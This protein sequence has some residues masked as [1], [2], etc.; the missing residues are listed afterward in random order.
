[1]RKALFTILCMAI[2]IM[3]KAQN[4]NQSVSLNLQIVADTTLHP[5]NGNPTTS[6]G[7][8]GHIRFTSELGFVRFVVNDNYDD[9]YM[10]YESYRLFE[11][12][13]S[14]NFSQRCE[15][16]CF[17][18]SYVPTELIVQVKDAIVTISTID[19]SNAFYSN[20]EF[21][22]LNA[23]QNANNQKLIKVQN[24][25]QRKGLI[26]VADATKLSSL[27]YKQ[28]AEYYGEGYRTYGYEFYS[29][30]FFS[31][32]GPDRYSSSKNFVGNFDWRNRHG[33]NNSQSSYYDGDPLGTGW[34]TPVVCQSE[35]CWLNGSFDCYL[36][37]QQ[38]QDLGGDYREA[39]TCWI[40]GPTA[41]VEAMTNL[42]YN[43]HLDVDLSEQ[44]I[45]CRE[46]KVSGSLP[47]YALKYYKQD[48]VPLESCLAYSASLGNCSD[49]CA[50][51]LVRVR[52]SNY[53]NHNYLNTL[54]D[55]LL[56]QLIIN[57]G[58]LTAGRLPL[59]FGMNNHCMLL[60]GWGTID[61]DIVSEVLGV[62]TYGNGLYDEDFLGL[63]Y[64][65]YK[66]SIGTDDGDNGFK[67]ILHI[68]NDAPE[69]TGSVTTPIYYDNLTERDVRCCDM[70]GDGYY[71]WGIGP[72]P[73]HCPPCPDEPD[74]D[75]SNPNLGPLNS[76]GQCTIIGTY[77][78][79]FEEGWDNWMQVDL[80]NQE[81]GIFWRDNRPS[82]TPLTGPAYAQDGDYY[83]YVN[84]RESA[85]Y[86]NIYSILESPDINIHNSCYNVLDFY[87]HMKVYDWNNGTD[88]PR[89][90]MMYQTSDNNWHINYNFEETGDHGAE[91]Q[92]ASVIL[93]LNVKKIRLYVK[94]GQYQYSDVALD[95]I[96]IGPWSHNETPIVITDNTEWNDNLTIN[97]DIVVENGGCLTIK[98]TS[99][100]NSIIK[101]HS[102]SKIIVKQGGRLILDHCTLTTLCSND[103]W[104]G[105][106]VWGN[107]NTHQ[108]EVNGSYLQ[109]YIELKNGAVIENAKCAVE[110]WHPEIYSTSGGIIHA[111]DATFRNNAKAVHALYYTYSPSGG[112]S[113]YNGYLR[114]CTFTIDEDY[115]GTETFSKHVD[116]SHISGFDIEGC[117]FSTMRNVTGVSP[118]CVGIGAYS[119][120]F[121]VDSY[122]DHPNAN[123]MTACPE[124]NL[125]PCSF[126]NFYQGIHASCDKGSTC[127]FRIE[128]AVFSNNTCG[129]YALNT[130]YGIVVNNDFTVG[131]GWDCDFGI[132]ADGVSNFCIEDNTFQP[133]V[134]NTG[135]PY[136]IAIVNSKSVND[137]YNNDFQNL[138]CGNVA[139][140]SNIVTRNSPSLTVQGLT[141]TCN[142]NS[143]NLIDFCVLKD[144][145]TGDIATQQGS[146]T[147][148]AG[149]TFSGSQYHFYNDGNNWIGYYYEQNNPS[150]TP[151]NTSLYRVSTHFTSSSNSCNSHY[152]G[153]SVTKSAAEKAALASEYLS[154]R[155]TYNSLLQL[156][157]SRIDGGSTPAQVTDINTATPSDLWQL[158]A[159]L[160]G[161][162]PYVSGEV[163]TTAADRYDVFTDPVLFEIL[164]ANPDELRKD[165]LISYLETKDHPLPTYMTDLLRE[166][167]SGFTAR[168][169]LLG[170]MAQYGHDFRLAAGDIVRSC[171]NDSVTDLTELRTW[172]ANMD[173]IASDRMIVASYLQEGDSVHAFGLANMLPELYGLQGD[174]LADHTDYMR[175]IELYQTLNRES[176]NVNTLTDTELS[177]VNGIA[178]SGTGTSKTMAEAIL[179]ERSDEN[180]LSSE[181]P[182]MPG[183]NGGIRGSASFK[184]TSLNEA[185]GFTASVSPNPATTWTTVEYTLPADKSQ[186]SFS[187]TNT[188]GVIVMSTELNG[189]QGQK[190]LDLHGLADGVYFYTIRCGEYTTTGKLV[191]TK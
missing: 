89:I 156:Y 7:I 94:T 43:R 50:D 45:A 2:G 109:G 46:H 147:M 149:N 24:Y 75:D 182:T 190:V 144:G 129:L 15:E 166:M 136:G 28:K 72:K 117:S 146:A 27:S 142:T 44:Y 98:K 184:D 124:E 183:N 36:D 55:M 133:K 160:L 99:G 175:L 17:F 145:N 135:S 92:H 153:G 33:A 163:L 18:G 37:A 60:V 93:P 69:Y 116:L 167:A 177:M 154:A 90:T 107:S 181:C 23:T 78:A 14:F 119:A 77:T 157:E 87:Y 180:I 185:M 132:Y 71:N 111:T 189:K 178:A 6:I 121:R 30:G 58:P 122:C 47:V 143:G 21:L 59:G 139:V 103:M 127:S 54:T 114:N 9:E 10:V 125:V 91:W 19:M 35:G 176:R 159:Q 134:T 70:D 188:L 102:D 56:K 63:T 66:E 141:Y 62:P 16:S 76:Y 52:I 83:I 137:V 172:L 51:S 155:S 61:D 73:A 34:I 82:S 39:S 8:S 49:L 96:T 26:W 131:C 32:F 79:S 106:E 48:G 186:A 25:I 174:A 95:N 100:N 138:R 13:S 152:N 22:R 31:I 168:T 74:G 140:G 115:L 120:G 179:M 38:C 40:F 88:A 12:D 123:N 169:A 5:F 64:W 110:L 1:M 104:Q 85:N 113:D 68:D 3:V 84:S 148:P 112:T 41:Q 57:N 161:I 171:L 150:Q 126:T 105:I 11:N 80:P 128:N 187:V 53:S 65:I 67:Y 42:Y 101:L 4:F 191:I 29:K 173:D 108:H 164:A 118:Y 97:Q 170:Q 86:N 81:N 158:R 130:S 165:S 20:S 162:S 151:I